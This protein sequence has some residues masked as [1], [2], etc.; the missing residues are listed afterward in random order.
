MSVSN[1]AISL[2]NDGTTIKVTNSNST[3]N[4]YQQGT[5]TFNAELGGGGGGG[6][7]AS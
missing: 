5:F 6:Y 7:V 3:E 1:G 2:T 4:A